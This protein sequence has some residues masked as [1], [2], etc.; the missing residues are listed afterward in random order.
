MKVKV[1]PILVFCVVAVV[2]SALILP[3]SKEEKES[4]S[5]VTGNISE[6][7]E[8][9]DEST[10]PNIP[11]LLLPHPKTGGDSF[12]DQALLAMEEMK[13]ISATL[14]LTIEIPGETLTG[15][16]S[17]KEFWRTNS[18]RFEFDRMFL[19]WEL[20]LRYIDPDAEQEGAVENVDS[21][22][23][24]NTDEDLELYALLRVRDPAYVWEYRKFGGAE[25]CVRLD[26][27]RIAHTLEE[28]SINP[29]FSQ[30]NAWPELGGLLRMLKELRRHYEFDETIDRVFLRGEEPVPVYL[31]TGRFRPSEDV[32]QANWGP[33]P[34]PTNISIAFGRD[35]YFPYRIEFLADPASHDAP[36]N[37]SEDSSSPLKSM[38]VLEF[39][40]V[41]LVGPIPEEMFS[42][43][44]ANL[45]STSEHGSR[46]VDGTEDFL[47]EY[48]LMPQ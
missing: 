15:A 28:I 19:R 20:Y 17:Y 25:E 41:D 2:G 14:D 29:S 13:S 22:G 32:A 1:I 42:F 35:N 34:M 36:E 30:I 8:N 38:L 27:V 21:D 7:P 26:L 24:T 33:I 45:P 43:L 12:F 18:T 31:V 4:A 40:E 39:H 47:K 10:A 48:G 9:P 23:S 5:E 3:E 44:P 16:G 46:F 6:E 37:G 11:P